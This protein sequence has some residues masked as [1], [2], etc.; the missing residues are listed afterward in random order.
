MPLSDYL[1][2]RLPERNTTIPH[3]QTSQEASSQNPNNDTQATNRFLNNTEKTEL[4][5]LYS[6]LTRSV[7]DLLKLDKDV[8]N[9]KGRDIRNKNLRMKITR[10]LDQVIN[11]K[12]IVIPRNSKQILLEMVIN[13][14]LG[15]GPLEPLLADDNISEIMITGIDMIY[16]ERKGKLEEVNLHFDS[17]DQLLQIIENIVAPIGRHIDASSPLVDARLP[18]GS[19]VNAI[20]P[21]LAPK[22][23]TV[24]IR[25]F[26]KTALSV[27]DLLGFG[28]LTQDMV[29]FIEACVRGKLNVIVSGG[30]G[31][32]KTTTL[33]ILSAII[34]D[35]ERIITVE[36]AAELQLQQE[37]V[38][39]METRPAN[40]EGKGQ[41]VIRDLVANALRMRPDRIIV[42]ECRGGE[43]LDMLQVMNTGNDGSMTTLHAN[44][45]KECIARLESLALMSGVELPSRAIREQISSAVQLIVHQSRLR[46]G[47]RKITSIS[48]VI[49]T[50]DGEPIINPIFEFRM[51]G[52]DEEKGKVK[53]RHVATGNKPYYLQR[54]REYGENVDESLF[55]EPED[56]EWEKIKKEG[57][58]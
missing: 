58:L 14:I 52:Y 46:D 9:I 12:K 24:T 8:E 34:P 19:R 3:A 55:V 37:H 23:P 47:S 16:V 6:T 42:G 43:A 22:G 54:L 38:V 50:E 15:F 57:M 18:D 41:I 7:Q 25:K 32:G 13:N 10:I 44:N 56:P 53:G 33:N 21:P 20:I 36:D 5:A 40:V 17:E 31:S 39:S 29:D 11:E 26:A 2:G 48:E 51:Y 1:K 30:T 27:R 28:S 35:N 4:E 45:P 49:K